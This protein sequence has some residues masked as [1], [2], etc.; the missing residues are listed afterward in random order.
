MPEYK[1]SYKKKYEKLLQLLQRVV[2]A[3]KG[4]RR[5]KMAVVLVEAG[6]LHPTPQAIAK[7]KEFS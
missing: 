7:W 6:L 5:N 4:T 2:D 1:I 3:Q